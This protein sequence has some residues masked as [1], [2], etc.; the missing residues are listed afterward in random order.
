MAYGTSIS[1][2]AGWDNRK[3]GAGL[4]Q[5]NQMRN[6]AIQGAYIDPEFQGSEMTVPQLQPLPGIEN[7]PENYRQAAINRALSPIQKMNPKYMD[8]DFSKMGQ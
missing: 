6:Q 4:P 7:I 5:N 3:P 1:Q 2:A 8:F